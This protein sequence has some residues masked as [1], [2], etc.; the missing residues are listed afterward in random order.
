MM[1]VPALF[2]VPVTTISPTSARRL[3]IV[4]SMGLT[5]VVYCNWSVACSISASAASI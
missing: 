2:I 3:V 4:P 1:T 5:I